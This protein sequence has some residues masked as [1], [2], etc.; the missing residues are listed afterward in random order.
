[1]QIF[2][3]IRNASVFPDPVFAP[4]STSQPRSAGKMADLWISVGS[5]YLASSSP[6]QPTALV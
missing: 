5:P 2:T 4:A 3:G 1:M 6:V